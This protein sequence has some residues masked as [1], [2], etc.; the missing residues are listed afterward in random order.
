MRKIQKIAVFIFVMFTLIVVCTA[1]SGQSGAASG[2]ETDTF[3]D[4]IGRKVEIPKTIRKVAAIDAFTGEAMV[5]MG[6]GSYMAACPEGVRSDMLLQEIYPELK[7]VAVVQ[8]GGSINAEALL[9]L[10]PDVVLVKYALYMTEGEVAKL[11]KLG[12]PYLV[13][14]YTNMEEQIE[15][16]NLIGEVVGGKPLEKAET[17]CRYYEDTIH[18]VTEI[19]EKIPQKEK[20][21]VYHSIN[22]T[23]RTDGED[24]LGADWIKAVGCK[25]VSADQALT[26]DGGGYF[27]SQEQV[28]VWNPDVIICNA[29]LT[30]KYFEED[31]AWQGLRAV[32]EGNVHNIPVGATRWGQEG[33]VE[34]FFGMLWLGV[35]VYPEYYSQV[36]LKNEVVTFYRDVL[37]IELDDATY[38]KILSGDGIR[39]SSQNAGK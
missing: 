3:I 5:M 21:A 10:D 33:S 39:A 30:K 2:K 9:A 4:C 36:N 37:G 32:Y 12:I 25:D 8:S 6:A 38:E 1:C 27:A 18:L 14:E 34:T 13:I 31:A 20:L 28:F 22:Q 11:D 16:L 19:S 15:A 29:A 35:T 26:S 7:D 23:F 24:S 17:I